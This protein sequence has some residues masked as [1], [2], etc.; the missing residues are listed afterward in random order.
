MNYEDST[1]GNFSFFAEENEAPRPEVVEKQAAQVVEEW[2]CVEGC[3]CLDLDQQSGVLT[4]GQVKAGYMRNNSQHASNGGYSG[5]LK[6][7]PLMGY[8][9]SG[10]ASRFFKQV[11]GAEGVCEY[12]RTMISPPLA[13]QKPVAEVLASWSEDLHLREKGS[14]TGFIIHGFVPS[15]EQA[16]VLFGLLCPGGHIC[17]VAPDEQ[18]TGHTGAIRL[19]DAGFEIRDAILWVRGPGRLHYVPKAGRK[20]R[21][22][23]CQKLQ[24][25]KGFEAVER[26]EGSAGTQSPR[27]GA[28]RTATKVRNFHP[29]VKPIGVMA[30]LLQDVPK[31]QGPVLDPFMGSGTT[32]IACRQT[33]HDAIGIER[34]VEYLPISEAR[35]RHWDRATTRPRE[36]AKIVTDLPPPVDEARAVMDEFDPIPLDETL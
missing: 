17:L 34:D 22:A 28:G 14:S 24:A 3:P 23:G 30:R 33:G 18:P 7:A 25:K 27:A 32:L 29:T 19:E 10:G 15:E 13:A 31:A 6:D 5:G 16:T 1:A 4:S 9:D 36:G 12:L 11:Q 20:E 35:V 21:E 26:A 2:A 8:G